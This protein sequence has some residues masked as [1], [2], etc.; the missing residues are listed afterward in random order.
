ML[1]AFIEII[2]SVHVLLLFRLADRRNLPFSTVNAANAHKFIRNI[3]DIHSDP[4]VNRFS[5]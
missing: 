5:W 1:S 4:Q 3:D 2:Y